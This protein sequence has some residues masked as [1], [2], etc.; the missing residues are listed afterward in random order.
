MKENMKKQKI[1]YFSIRYVGEG[2]RYCTKY[3]NRNYTVQNTK[4]YVLGAL[5]ENNK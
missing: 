4:I 3:Q 2:E 1:P 5:I